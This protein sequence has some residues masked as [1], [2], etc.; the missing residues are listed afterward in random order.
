[1]PSF[2]VPPCLRTTL[3]IVSMVLFSA[4]SQADAP[5]EGLI[6]WLDSADLDGDG[7]TSNETLSGEPVTR[8][9]DKSS[10]GNHLAQPLAE[11]QPAVER[12]SASDQPVVRF[13]GD[14]F[15]ALD[16]L[17]GL[18]IGDQMFHL[19]IVMHAPA[20]SEHLSQRILDFESRD[21][22]GSV[23]KRRG[24]WVGD[25]Q[26]RKLVRFGIN[27]GDEGEGLHVAWDGEPH[28]LELV[29]TS[30]QMFEMY[31]DGQ[32]ERRAMFNGTHFL[33]LTDHV[34]L[35]LGQHIHW[36]DSEQTF[37][38]GDLGEVLFYNRPLSTIERQEV[39]RYLTEKFSLSTELA[40]IPQFETEVQPILAKHCFDCHGDETREAQ[41]DLR[42]VSSMLIGG[43]AGPVIVRGEPAYS[44]LFTRIESG[45][46]PPEGEERLTEDELH[47]IREWIEADAPA[48]EQ[49]V[50]SVPPSKITDEDR[51]HWAWN[52]PRHH[53][54]PDVQQVER[55]S[56][57]IDRF[58]L[59]RLEDAGLSFS[60][61]AEAHALVRRVYFDLIGLPPSPPEVQQFADD[62]SPGAYERLIDR[63]LESQHFGE[64]WGRHWLDVVGFVDVHGS[65]NDFAII[66]PLPGKWRYRDYVVRSFNQDKP[67]NRFITE[68]LAGDELCD[69]RSAETFTPEMLDNLIA[70]TFLLCANDDSSQNELNTP[71]IRHHVLQRTSET[72]ANA[73]LA[74]TME[75]AKC[76]DHKYE[77]ISQYDYYS[78]ESIF[79]PVFN[80][81]NWVTAENHVRPD[82]SDAERAEIDQ[83]NATI[84]SRIDGLTKRGDEIHLTCRG[85]ILQQRLAEL[86]DDIRDAVKSAIETPADNRTDELKQ[87]AQAHESSIV[88]SDDQIEAAL[89][90]KE[91][92][93][94]SEIER[95]MA[96]L[97]AS[98]R[99][100]DQI[101]WAVENAAPPATH[102]LRRGNY[103]RPGLEV[104]PALLD[105]LTEE[106]T[107]VFRS[108][109]EDLTATSGRR[110]ELARRLT[111]SDTLAGSYVARVIVNRL[112]QQLF[113]RGIVE[114]SD[115]FGVSGSPPSHPELLD[116]L[117]MEFVREGWRV[118]PLIKSMMM[119][120]AYRQTSKTDDTSQL[121]ETVDPA[122]KLLWRMNLRRLDSEQIRDAMLT[123][124]GKLDPSIGG[125]PL[126]LDVQPDGMVLIKQDGLPYPES[127]WRRS[128]YV[129]ARR[130]YQLTMLRMF[131]QPIVTRNCSLRKPT[132][133]VTQSLTLLHDDFVLEQAQFMADRA[134]DESADHDSAAL[135]SW[136]F[137][138][139]LGRP[140]DA[141]E[142]AWS[143]ELLTR[144]A[145]RYQED[146]M[147]A[148]QANLKA[149]MDVCHM[150]LN[151]N[152]FLYLP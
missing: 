84:N 35:A 147:E 44:E 138:A 25:Q 80:V 62:T 48:E 142:T 39:N 110:L 148:E 73:L 57:D 76:H 117:T 51:R 112:W 55:V 2:F 120:S 119:S 137:M 22:D 59:A 107:Q 139:A 102:V 69:W 26:G 5:R 128:I 109:S 75:C 88:P 134:R 151:T 15:L 42:T 90:D 77:P 8:W 23:P 72:V 79:A 68:Q 63:L 10:Q 33:G 132:A 126:P 16:R 144:H 150:L 49:I 92:H 145:A 93:E 45:Q 60:R 123:V 7:N 13:H 83:A 27:E 81:R 52:K 74:V 108:E 67:F 141:E 122:N 94:C 28:L 29:Y 130:N 36:E 19:V 34:S 129:L 121:A 56:N 118:K 127:Q 20:E 1:M 18:R 99:S 70:T 106:S 46:M 105:I 86:P 96:D 98:L 136:S 4:T 21:S 14:D 12:D 50:I 97:R 47:I 37:Y 133:V 3:I 58:V 95:E 103:L 64:R 31:F 17:N 146:G 131:D 135:I 116:W 65:D 30:E 54:P 152:E 91:R 87:L 101:T 100:Y 11:R 89:T 9:V 43:E 38:Q 53:E 140:A 66:K 111:D 104:H 85:R 40:E 78:F 143:V 125:E 113:G 71:D 24:F 149:M 82:V 114:T 124:S 41:L 6:L 32:R 115:N 61:E